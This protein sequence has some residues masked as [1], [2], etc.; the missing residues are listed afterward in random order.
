[1]PAARIVDT[2]ELLLPQECNGLNAHIE[3][4]IDGESAFI[5]F[6]LGPNRQMQ[7]LKRH[8]P[9]FP[10][11]DGEVKESGSRKN[12]DRV[13]GRDTVERAYRVNTVNVPHR[14]TAR[15]DTFYASQGHWRIAEVLKRVG[16][17]LPA[18]RQI[19]VLCCQWEIFK[20]VRVLLGTQFIRPDPQHPFWAPH[21]FGQFMVSWCPHPSQKA[22]DGT[23]NFDFSLAGT[24]V[25]RARLLSYL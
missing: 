14:R 21:R 3:R 15:D 20:K 12:L 7:D 13:L 10:A 8:W 5:I 17:R 19:V 1:M 22:K 6:G 4:W 25:E 11:G 2:R 9:A 23:C 24:E 16:E 18:E